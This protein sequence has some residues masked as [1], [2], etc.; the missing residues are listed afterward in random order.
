MEKGKGK[1]KKVELAKRRE[2]KLVSETTRFGNKNTITI[3][4]CQ[5]VLK[6][7]WERAESFQES[8]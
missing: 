1:T 2:N 6:Q 5:I 7:L 3:D 8:G 4:A